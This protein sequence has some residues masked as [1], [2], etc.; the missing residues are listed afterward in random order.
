MSGWKVD[1]T[2]ESSFLPSFFAGWCCHL[3]DLHHRPA[4]CVCGHRADLQWPAQPQRPCRCQCPDEGLKWLHV[5]LL[6]HCRNKANNIF[7]TLPWDVPAPLTCVQ[8]V[9]LPSCPLFFA[10]NEELISCT[11]LYSPSKG[12]GCTL[13]DRTFCNKSL[14]GLPWHYFLTF[15]PALKKYLR[16]AWV[17]KH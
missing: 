14:R 11:G 1:S 16:S 8:C 13:K 15:G 4:Y 7:A 3:H 10:S 6:I 17:L 12:Q 5:L 2:H 9:L